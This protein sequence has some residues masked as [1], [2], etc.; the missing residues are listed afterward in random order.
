MC[1]TSWSM[2][3]LRMHASPNTIRGH[4]PLKQII[5]FTEYSHMPINNSVHKSIYSL[6]CTCAGAFNKVA[7]RISKTALNS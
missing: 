1:L 6:Y 3:I 5:T 7:H 4:D 2:V